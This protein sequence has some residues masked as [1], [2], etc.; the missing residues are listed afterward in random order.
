MW[1]THSAQGTACVSSS[2]Q[3][4]LS[5]C[6][7]E[8]SRRTRLLQCLRGEEKKVKRR[9]NEKRKKKEKTQRSKRRKKKEEKRE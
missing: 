1:A 6:H 8:G 3:H 9:R 4:R 2:A 5:W 7:T